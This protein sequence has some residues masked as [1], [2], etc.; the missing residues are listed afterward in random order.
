MKS[1]YGICKET[2]IYAYSS[3]SD[4]VGFAVEKLKDKSLSE[5]CEIKQEIEN[6][7]NHVFIIEK[8]IISAA[9]VFAIISLLLG[10]IFE[11]LLIIKVSNIIDLSLILLIIIGKILPSFVGTTYVYVAAL[12]LFDKKSNEY[13]KVNR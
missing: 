1:L 2:G 3:G 7:K 10:Y 5:L 4:P 9:I 8:V 6:I 11:Y 12:Y 13:K